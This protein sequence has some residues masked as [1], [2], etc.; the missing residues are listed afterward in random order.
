[1]L[2]A[3]VASQLFGDSE[4]VGQML[5][6]TVGQNLTLPLRVVGVLAPQGGT[7]LGS[8]DEYVFVPITTLLTRVAS[9]RTAR[10]VA[11][12]NTITVQISGSNT[13]AAAKD[14]ITQLLM[15][16]HRVSDPDFIIQSQEDVLSTLQSITDA[17]TI[18]LSSIAG[19]S[20]LVGGIG[21]MNI[22]LVSVTERTREIGIR[23]ALGARRW[24]IL[25]Q[26]LVEALTVSVG[27]GLLG[28]GLGVGLSRGASG[29]T[30]GGR[31]IVTAITPQAVILSFI[32]A[33]AIG[34]FFGL[35]P[36]VRAARLDPIV[37]LRYE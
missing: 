34:V 26:F 35:Y 30:L 36:A 4:A 18:L 9:Q 12:L 27:G 19:I 28:L 13:L 23:K 20:L 10:G 7:A 8:L 22:M 14:A 11:N 24:D 5:R 2:G 16:R 32:V 15:D 1:V 31:V 3:Q 17:E 6:V 21:I 37:A 33:A 25:Q 29:H